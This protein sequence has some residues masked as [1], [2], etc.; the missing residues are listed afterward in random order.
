MK[1][2]APYF[3]PVFCTMAFAI[4]L[5]ILF[6]RQENKKCR[7]ELRLNESLELMRLRF[8]A[9]ERLILLMERLKPEA[10]VLREQKRGLTTLQFQTLLL[11]I[12][13]QEF[14]HNIAMQ[15]YVDDKTWTRVKAAKEALVKLINTTATGIANN[16]SALELSRQ[17]IEGAGGETILYFNNAI[18]AIREEMNKLYGK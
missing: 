16:A 8:Q 13:R 11:K 15:L 12:I 6:L 18:A 9:Y 4:V 10:L 2:L 1:E 17:I 7:H 3:L 14:D 5:T